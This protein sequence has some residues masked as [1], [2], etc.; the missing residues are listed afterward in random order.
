MAAVD[1][2]TALPKASRT[3]TAVGGAKGV[4]AVVL[5]GCVVNARAVAGPASAVAAIETGEPT[6]PAMAALACWRPDVVPRVH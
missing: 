1:D 2:V 3:L 5:E 6:T 4:P